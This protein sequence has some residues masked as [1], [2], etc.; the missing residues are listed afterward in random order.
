MQETQVKSWVRKA[1]PQEKEMVS[2]T[3]IL[4]WEIHGHRGPG[5]LQS[6]ELRIVRHDLVTET[7]SYLDEDLKNS[8]TKGSR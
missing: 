2:H 7:M 8:S 6:M 4:A 3:S 1:D 5:G